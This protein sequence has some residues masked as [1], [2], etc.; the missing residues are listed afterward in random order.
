MDNLDPKWLGFVIYIPGTP[1]APVSKTPSVNRYLVS[2]GFSPWKYQ[3]FEFWHPILQNFLNIITVKI[4]SI[5]FLQTKYHFILISFSYISIHK[6]NYF[7]KCW[8]NSA[9]LDVKTQI[10]CS[11]NVPWFGRLKPILIKV[12]YPNKIESPHEFMCKNLPPI[13]SAPSN[14]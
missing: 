6:K 4:K 8:E 13:N 2:F 7:N 1:Y 10:I 5:L 3:K 12:M 14:S 11:K 9:K